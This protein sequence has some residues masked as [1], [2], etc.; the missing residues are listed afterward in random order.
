[1]WTGLVWLRAERQVA[2]ASECSNEP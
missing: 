2:C 1:V